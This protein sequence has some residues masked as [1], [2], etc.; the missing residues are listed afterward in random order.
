MCTQEEFDEIKVLAE[1]VETAMSALDQAIRHADERLYDRW[2]AYGKQV[3]SEFVCGGPN[4]QE[5][6]EK[7]ESEIE[8]EKDEEE[9]EQEE[10]DGML[11]QLNSSI[12]DKDEFNDM[13]IIK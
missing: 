1:T 11:N 4:L 7:L 10:I 13:K 2:R 5:V 8:E 3:T 6:V 9:T 12:P